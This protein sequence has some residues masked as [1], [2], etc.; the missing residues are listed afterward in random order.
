MTVSSWLQDNHLLEEIG[1][2][3]RLL[4]LIERTVSAANIDRYAELVMDKY[5]RR[6][7]ISTGGEIIELARDTTLEL[8]NVFDESEQKIFRLTQKRPQ[9]GFNFSGGYF[10]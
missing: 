2:M 6:Q 1:G 10:N 7:L 8:E 9:E 3:P 4:Q 5:M